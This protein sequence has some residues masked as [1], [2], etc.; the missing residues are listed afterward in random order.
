MATRDSGPDDYRILMLAPTR[1][2]REVMQELLQ[3]AKIDSESFDCARSLATQ[4]ESAV[5]AVLLTD[6]VF[7]DPQLNELL[8]AL[9]RQ[10]PWSDIPIIFLYASAQLPVATRVISLLHNVTTLE[11]PSSSRTIISSIQAALRA[12]ARQ[13]QMRDQ[14]ALLRKSEASH[15]QSEQRFRTMADTIPQLAWSAHA[16][17]YVHWYNRRWY[18]YTGATPEQME[19]WGWQSVH[20]PDRLPAVLERW[21]RSIATGTPFEMEYP[22]ISATGQARIFLTRAVPMRDA[23]GR[24]I[25]WFGTSTD[26]DE[27]KQT[28]N[29]LRATE[30]ALRES[31]QRKDIFLATLAHELRNPLAPIR[32]VAQLLGSPKLDPQQL[33]FAQGVIQR[34]VK[35]MAWLLDDLLDVARITQG[36][37][38]LKKERVMLTSI[39]DAAVETARPLLDSKSHHLVVTLPGQ[40]IQLEVDPLRL[41][42]V[43]SNFLTN[44]AKYTDAGGHIALSGSVRDGYLYLIVKDN[45]IGIAADSLNQLF[46]MFSQVDGASVRAEG[47]LG[48]GLALAKGL[49]ELHGGIVEVR[50]A[51]LGQ[52]SEF[53]ARLALPAMEPL[54]ASTPNRGVPGRQASGRRILVADDNKDAADALAMLLEIA[55]HEVRV[56]HNGRAALTLAQTFRPEVGLVDIGMPELSGYEVAR[57]LRHEQWGSDIYLIALTGWGQEGDRQQ[58]LEAGF[59]CHLTKPIDPDVLETFLSDARQTAQLAS[60]VPD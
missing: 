57:A 3:R 39:V 38:V 13:Y 56:A 45:G 26:I 46:T 22:L 11:R 44:A 25:Q 17:G 33:H 58:A 27:A 36:K 32:T 60:S 7:R 23:Q 29:K 9:S 30:A 49:M 8:T 43:L 6:D 24:V 59:D 35:H 20:D 42:Q 15:E 51:G 48:I 47:G 16:D 53:T 37:L 4:V 19:G 5:G 55:G 54:S 21:R 2:D 40:E 28:E 12:R 10:P 50:S 31:D 52:G 1:R 18:E 34:Q 41:S 14:F